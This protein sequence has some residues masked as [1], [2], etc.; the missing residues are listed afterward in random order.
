MRVVRFFIPVVVVLGGLVACGEEATQP[1]GPTSQVAA[2]NPADA[3]AADARPETGASSCTVYAPKDACSTGDVIVREGCPFPACSCPAECYALTGTV[4]DANMCFHQDVILGCLPRSIAS[5][6]ASTS[7]CGLREADGL[8]ASVPYPL[9]RESDNRA[10]DTFSV[11]P[12][13]VRCP[14]NDEAASRLCGWSTLNGA[15]CR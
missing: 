12:G 13:W 8:R 7:R 1:S 2:T 9:A 4:V 3:A 6:S 11:M 5:G 14:D 15:Q 10:V